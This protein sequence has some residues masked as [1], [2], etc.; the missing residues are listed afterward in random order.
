MQLDRRKKENSDSKAL[1]FGGMAILASAIGAVAVG[2]VAIG[3]FSIR[4]LAIRRVAIDIGELKSLHI[5]DLTV[6][7]LHATEV[8]VSE[9]LKVPR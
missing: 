8:T 2:A 4:R 6:G 7:R 5:Q 3:V 9:S 1:G